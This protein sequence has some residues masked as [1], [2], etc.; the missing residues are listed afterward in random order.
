MNRF[1]AVNWNGLTPSDEVEAADWIGPR[2]HPFAQDVGSIVP[3]GFEAYARIFHPARKLVGVDEVEMRW[4]DVA[5]WSGRTVHPEMQFHS[6]AVPVPDRETRWQA[7]SQ[8]PRLGA[9][10]EGQARALVRLLAAH[11]SNAGECW[12]CVWEGYGSI[13]PNPL[14]QPR[15][16]AGGLRWI[17]SL[18]WRLGRTL[19]KANPNVP[20][21]RRVRLPQRNYILFKGPLSL[22]LG[23]DGGPNLWWPD[24]RSWCVASEIDF[25]YTYVGGSKKLIEEIL[26]DPAIEALPATLAQGVTAFSDKVNASGFVGFEE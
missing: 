13:N 5:E 20:E 8:E 7:W 10:S 14:P 11:T 6:I 17:R 4:S 26:V 19:P 2:L 21:W 9:L 12:F 1:A 25:P 16:D 15:A 23:H 18:W 3:S 22:A 24:D